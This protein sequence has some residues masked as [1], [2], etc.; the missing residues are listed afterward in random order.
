M[1]AAVAVVAFCAWASRLL[2]RSAMCVDRARMY[3]AHDLGST[4]IW[5]GPREWHRLASP[6][7]ARLLW[8]RQMA[9]K[10]W[11]A[12]WRPWITVP[13]DPPQPAS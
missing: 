8:R 12:A 4:N 9:R 2:S 1:M 11:H 5:M 6:P 10:Y 7:S 3:E 13:S